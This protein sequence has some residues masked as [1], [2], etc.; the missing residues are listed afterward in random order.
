M[1]P[2][3]IRGGELPDEVVLNE[4]L[5]DMFAQVAG[6]KGLDGRSFSLDLDGDILDG[7]LGLPGD[8]IG[9]CIVASSYGAI[10]V[11]SAPRIGTKMRFRLELSP[12][13]RSGISPGVGSRS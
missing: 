9:L 13:S 10:A 4:E 12:S 1:D 7:L 8:S 3:F 6:R 5:D 11:R 2:P